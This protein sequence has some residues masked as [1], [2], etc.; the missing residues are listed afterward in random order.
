MLSGSVI[1]KLPG[2]MTTS[3]AGH[4]ERIECG[5]QR[6]ELGG[7]EADGWVCGVERKTEGDEED[8]EER[9]H[10]VSEWQE[11]D[12]RRAETLS[13]LPRAGN[14]FCQSPP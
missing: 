9:F 5:L 1:S 6:R 7:V 11:G 10:E 12:G 4:R 13:L 3:A 14:P 8:N 2:G